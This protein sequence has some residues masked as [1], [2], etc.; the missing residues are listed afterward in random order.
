M[1]GKVPSQ[2]VT[3]SVLAPSR[4]ECEAACLADNTCA[5]F[6]LADTGRGPSCELLSTWQGVE[7]DTTGDTIFVV[8]R[9]ELTTQDEQTIIITVVVMRNRKGSPCA[10]G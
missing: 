10:Q 8:C 7:D 3:N 6:T 2:P 1:P 9:G 4:E 5:G